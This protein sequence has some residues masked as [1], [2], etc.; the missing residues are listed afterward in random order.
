MT[1][2]VKKNT[3]MANPLQKSKDWLASH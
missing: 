3:K 1:R 2:C